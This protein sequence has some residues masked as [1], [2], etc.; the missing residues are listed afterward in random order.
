MYIKKFFVFFS[1]LSFLGIIFYGLSKDNSSKIKIIDLENNQNE[2]NIS[3]SIKP[4]CYEKK[5]NT[6]QDLISTSKIKIVI[7]KNRAWT[8]SLLKLNTNQN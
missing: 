3:D 8:K 5:I 6:H 4:F 1:F 2:K 7:P